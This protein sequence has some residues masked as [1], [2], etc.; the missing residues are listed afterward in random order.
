M[1]KP[2]LN[3]H[4]TQRYEL[5][6]TV[7]AP[8]SWDKISA[9]V[10]YNISNVECTPKNSFEGVHELPDDIDH[11]I[12]LTRVS[13]HTYK[14][15]FYRDLLEGGDYYGLGVCHWT[16]KGVGPSFTVHALSFTAGINL[17]EV[18]SGKSITQYFRKKEYFDQSM[19]DSNAGGAMLSSTDDAPGEWFP[20]TMTAKEVKP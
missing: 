15:Y 18:L 17:D 3:P 8:G 9:S 14:G 13:E 12:T 4:P 11:A 20:V 7:D 6:V 16:I 19:N 10:T 2:A 1:D 5:T